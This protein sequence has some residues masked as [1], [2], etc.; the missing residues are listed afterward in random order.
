MAQP[1]CASCPD[2]IPAGARSDSL[3]CS[4]RCRQAA[5]RF[6]RAGG[7]ARRVA[8]AGQRKPSSRAAA[9]RDASRSAEPRP[10]R[11]AYADPPYPGTA[12]R[13]YADHPD[14]D[15]EVDHG[16]LV[17][18]LVADF[19]D[20]WALSTSA[21]A[22]PEVLRLCPPEA[23][24][25]A[26]FRGERPTRSYR[27]LVS[28]EPVIYVGGRAYLS[29]VSERRLDALVH[30][31]RA[32]TTDARRVVG[33]KPAAFCYWLFMLLGTRPGDEL[34]DLFPGSGGV[35]RA[36]RD[37]SGSAVVADPHDASR[38]AGVAAPADATAG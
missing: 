10:L 32:R 22:L 21:A 33:A 28:W 36:W 4:K 37:F 9:R 35:A 3:Y 7:H 15:G 26:W 38:S 23:R 34:C 30:V 17:A 6:R 31:S 27:P 12:A 1:L 14:Y 13:Y 24:V 29:D 25:A 5:W 18:R 8:S 2:P 16:A 11:L 19:P 20:G